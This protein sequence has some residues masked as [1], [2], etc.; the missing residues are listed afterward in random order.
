[1]IIEA[2]D[3]MLALL[4]SPKYFNEMESGLTYRADVLGVN[5]AK[6]FKNQKS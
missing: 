5:W 6:A 3:C 1:M 2:K 4:D